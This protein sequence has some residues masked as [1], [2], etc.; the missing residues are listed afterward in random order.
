MSVEALRNELEQ[1]LGDLAKIGAQ[2]APAEGAA[3]AS[4]A[5][6]PAG[7]TETGEYTDALHK[8]TDYLSGRVDDAEDALA[9]HPF[10]SIGAAFMLGVA[11]GRLSRH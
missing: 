11:I 4:G 9:A 10:V 2:D 1:L 6:E 7:D 8:L 3:A 5:G